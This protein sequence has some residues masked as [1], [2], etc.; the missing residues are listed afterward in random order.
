[1]G[2]NGL[3][4]RMIGYGRGRL[5]ESLSFVPAE[6]TGENADIAFS[7]FFTAL[8]NAGRSSDTEYIKRD[9]I[10][11]AGA[12][13]NFV[14]GYP[15]DVR[16]HCTGR[17]GRRAGPTRMNQHLRSCQIAECEDEK[18]HTHSR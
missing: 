10:E 15:L 12:A 13:D 3:H 7:V 16:D 17:I 18:N 6:L 1:M 4:H 8:H 5:R 2:G 14:Q 11:L 9:I